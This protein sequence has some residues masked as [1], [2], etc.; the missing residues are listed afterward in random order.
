MDSTAA[1]NALLEEFRS[2]GGRA[3]NVIQRDGPLGLGLFPINP[4]QPV[5][6][7]VPKPLLVPADNVEL[8]N[9]AAVIKDDSM[10]P[11]GYADWFRRYQASYSWGAEGE[12]SVT[13]FETG[14]KNL[15]SNVGELLHQLNLYRPEHRLTGKTFQDSMLRRFLKSRCLGQQGQLLVMPLVELVNH[16]PKATNWEI[17]PDGSVGFS[18]LHDGEVLVKYSN[19]DPFRRLMGYGFNIQEPLGFSLSLKL[20]HRGELVVVQGG[21]GRHWFKPPALEQTDKRLMVQQPLLGCQENPRMPLT[22]FLSACQRACRP[23]GQELFERIHQANTLALM[24]LLKR[25]DAIQ[26]E[27]ASLL[28]LGCLNQL[29]ALSHHIGHRP[30]LIPRIDAL[31]TE[32][33]PLKELDEPRDSPA[34]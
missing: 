13:H 11:T 7:V 5:E 23:D 31:G 8:R 24:D 9:G 14:L 32:L 21:G 22:L 34:I 12:E 10:F 19:A 3:E 30:E 29:T 27:I 28:R 33:N 18:G 20:L 16:S 26:S 17:K 15:P 6:L 4:S 25:L 2:F 1:W